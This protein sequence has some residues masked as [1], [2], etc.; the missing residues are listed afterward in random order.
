MLTFFA[1]VLTCLLGATVVA[2]QST[3]GITAPASGETVAGVVEVSGT[4]VH[5]DFLRYELAFLNESSGA[6]WIVFAEGEAPVVDGVLAVWD[7]T[8]G[9]S[10]G[11]PVFPDGVYRLRLRV[12]RRDYNYDEFFTFNLIIQNDEPTPTPTTTA[13]ATAAAGSG[14][15]GPSDSPLVQPTPLPSLTPFPTVT[16][17]PTVAGEAAGAPPTATAVS[18]NLGELGAQAG[19]QL[20]NAFWLGVNLALLLFGL[21][22]L[23]LLLRSAGRR[24]WQRWWRER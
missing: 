14:S 5:P 1:V 6:G 11:A 17:P 3:S 19:A 22:L 8:V 10:I 23:D 20:S 12:V 18:A 13:T 4:A 7:T 9:R 15:S 16:P 2:A 24:L 21:L